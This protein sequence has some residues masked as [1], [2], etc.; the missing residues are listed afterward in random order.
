MKWTIERLRSVRWVHHILRTRNDS[1]KQYL[2]PS[3]CLSATLILFQTFLQFILFK[4]VVILSISIFR[5]TYFSRF[6]KKMRFE[7]PWTTE[8][9]PANIEEVKF[10]TLV[11]NY[12]YVL[13]GANYLM[14]LMSIRTHPW[15]WSFRHQWGNLTHSFSGK[16]IV[17]PEFSIKISKESKTFG[18][19]VLFLIVLSVV[20]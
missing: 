10:G 5:R 7:H 8:K 11:I 18:V 6:H 19:L 2:L 17:R 9:F 14:S 13:L 15:P 16:S 20:R 4:I 3:R 1:F 12:L